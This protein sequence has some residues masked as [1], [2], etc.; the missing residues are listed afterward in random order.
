LGAKVLKDLLCETVDRVPVRCRIDA[1]ALIV[2]GG[3][4][5]MRGGYE[6]RDNEYW[7]RL[8]RQRSAALRARAAV[9]ARTPLVAQAARMAVAEPHCQS[10]KQ[11]AARTGGFSV[12]LGCWETLGG[13]R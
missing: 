5:E 2:R 10:E 4:G 13:A 1:L 12:L 3:C 6:A 8:A 9:A 11:R 7:K